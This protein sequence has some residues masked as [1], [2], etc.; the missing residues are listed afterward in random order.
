MRWHASADEL[1]EPDG[2]RSGLAWL[3]FH[4]TILVGHEMP[5][6]GNVQ[7]VRRRRKQRASKFS[8]ILPF[9]HGRLSPRN[10]CCI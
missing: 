4:A 2:D 8:E 3:G 5:P 1:N 7:Q 10:Y 9:W 6:W